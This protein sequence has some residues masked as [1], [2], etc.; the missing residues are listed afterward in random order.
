MMK[1]KERSSELEVAVAG[2]DD[3][4]RLSSL[5]DDVIGRI[6][7]FLPARQAARTTQLSRR[8]RRVWPADVAALNLDWTCRCAS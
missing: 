4:D 3:D 7:S 5:P 2:D 1:R 8:W 6:L